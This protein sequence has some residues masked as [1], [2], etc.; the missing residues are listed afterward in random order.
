MSFLRL[1]LAAAVAAALAGCGSSGLGSVLNPIGGTSGLQCDPGTQV[2]LAN[3]QQ[4]ETG[5]PGNIGQIVIVAN[6]NGNPLGNSYGNWYVTLN[7]QYGDLITGG[8]LNPYSYPGGPQ[9]FGSD[10]YYSSS[11]P[12]LPSGAT[13]NAQLNESGANCLPYPLQSFST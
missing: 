10:Y 3:P 12:Q 9:P 5:V 13:W 11:I 6:G 7:D 8:N 4:G 2:Q 1:A